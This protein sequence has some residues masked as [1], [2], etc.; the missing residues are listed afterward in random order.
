MENETQVLEITPKNMFVPIC[1]TQA[2]CILVILIA[3]LIIKFF[4]DS[5]FKTL[6]TWCQNNVF[7][8]RQITANFDEEETNSEI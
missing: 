5:G 1:I 7:D 2:V 3:A 6:E 8:H 4:F